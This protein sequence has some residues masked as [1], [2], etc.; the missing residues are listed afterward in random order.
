MCLNPRRKIAAAQLGS[1]HVQAHRKIFSYTIQESK[2]AALARFRT[3]LIDV[4]DRFKQ[5]AEAM[6]GYGNCLR[7]SNRRNLHFVPGIFL[8]KR[9]DNADEP[10]RIS[11][12][13]RKQRPI[14]EIE[15]W[16]FSTPEPTN[17]SAA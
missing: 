16:I 8:K 7:L 5:C 11:L 9:R 10:A 15:P 14:S 1:Q 12:D 4:W 6:R 17:E 13:Y 2:E 3:R